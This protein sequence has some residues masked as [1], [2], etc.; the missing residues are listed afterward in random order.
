[1]ATDTMPGGSNTFIPGH[2]RKRYEEEG[3]Y[4][5][6]RDVPIF[7]EHHGQEEGEDL[8]F[9]PE[10]LEKIVTA[11]NRR[12]ADTG[13]CPVVTDGHIYPDE[14]PP[15]V[16]G[17][18]CDF[19]LGQIGNV[20]P[21]AA[22]LA[23]L[24][25]H[26]DKYERAKQLPRRSVE[27][28]PDMVADPVI[29]TDKKSPLHSLA[30]LGAERPARDLGL[31]AAKKRGQPHRYSHEVSHAHE[32]ESL[33]PEE[34][35]KQC[36][37]ALAQSPEMAFIRELMAKQQPAQEE[38]APEQFEAEEKSEDAEPAEDEGDEPEKY[39][40]QRD[41]ERRRYA[42]LQSAHDALAAKVAE[43]ET[44]ERISTRK[45]DLLGLEQ[46]G[47]C[48]DMA[49]ELE[50]VGD[51]EPARY[52]KHLATMRKR[53]QRAPV[54]VQINVKTVPVEG[55]KADVMLTPDQVYE[56]AIKKAN[57]KYAKK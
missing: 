11:C 42:K 25:I 19:K 38:P 57:E 6:V 16:L 26:K 29:L 46:E 5:V 56:A 55:G 31:L 14:P 9:T 4:V 18:A 28:W 33:N 13:D 2:D 34:I 37:E 17:F 7:D 15:D 35:I 54:G 45:A 30:L 3:D 44:K 50:L 39:K 20:R 53:Y 32:E 51:M 27:L 24:K 41:Q 52:S 47:I 10:V 36:L 23:T 43:L 48:F 12:I 49:E 1:M 22:I 8:D 21:R 40:M